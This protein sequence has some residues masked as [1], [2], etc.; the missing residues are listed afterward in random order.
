M[1]LEIKISENRKIRFPSH[2]FDCTRFL[3]YYVQLHASRGR[4][5]HRKVQEKLQRGGNSYWV[6]SHTHNFDLH[7]FF[8]LRKGLL[9][10]RGSLVFSCAGASTKNLLKVPNKKTHLWCLGGISRTESQCGHEPHSCLANTQLLAHCW[11]E[12]TSA[13][14]ERH[15]QTSKTLSETRHH[16]KRGGTL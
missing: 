10:L 13:L 2:L 7:S 4:W 6:F 3:H 8:F 11:E 5:A 1:K 14:R 16:K 9:T 15:F 12:N